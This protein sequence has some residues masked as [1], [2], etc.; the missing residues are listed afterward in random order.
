MIALLSDASALVLW[1]FVVKTEWVRLAANAYAD[2]LAEA[3]ESLSKPENPPPKL[4]V[5]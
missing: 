4:V 5:C 2:R 3:C 1:L